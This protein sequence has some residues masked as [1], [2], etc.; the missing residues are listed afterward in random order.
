MYLSTH[1]NSTCYIS[2]TYVVCYE[3]HENYYI[4]QKSTCYLC[5]LMSVLWWR[6][7]GYRYIQTDVQG[8]FFIRFWIT[9]GEEVKLVQ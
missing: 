4:Y 3:G 7:H 8:H 1:T 2:I 5:A 9:V 6:G